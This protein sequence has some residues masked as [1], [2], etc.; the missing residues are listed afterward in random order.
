VTSHGVQVG[1]DARELRLPDLIVIGAQKAGTSSVY[2]G[3]K[4]HPAIG[5][6][7][8]SEVEFFS[9]EVRYARGLDYYAAHFDHVSP[10]KL[11]AEVSP[12]YLYSSNTPRRLREA[13]PN[14]K[15]CVSLRDPVDR[16]F[17]AWRMQISKG[18]E[19]RPFSEAVRL[20]RRYVEYGL[21]YQQLSRYLDY[22]PM[23]QVLV[24]FFEDLRTNQQGYFD[25]I[26][27]F[28]GVPS[29]SIASDT[30]ENV[31]GEGRLGAVTA[32]LW[33]LF[34]A[35]N[36]IRR[37]ALRSVVDNYF[38]DT[39][40]RRLRNWVAGL[41]RQPSSRNESVDLETR[42]FI[43][44]SVAED[45]ISLSKLVGRDLDSWIAVRRQCP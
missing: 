5:V 3:L 8:R 29:V 19:R 34:S 15:L 10:E 11:T 27:E 17:S 32:I 13:I 33:Q 7:K 38:I 25:R 30:R 42:R 37:T 44:D 31:G 18:S 16:A 28:A 39:H 36:A 4:G 22:F 20:D 26:F 40:A 23:E 6:A 1:H 41:N 43:V 35:R 9:Q 12:G 14:V 24:Q 21:Y 45:V 2:A